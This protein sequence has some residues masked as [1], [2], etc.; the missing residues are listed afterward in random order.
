MNKSNKEL[1]DRLR[2]PVGVRED[3][4]EQLRKIAQALLHAAEQV[5][6]G[7]LR[8]DYGGLV[9]AAGPGGN[10][11]VSG[12]LKLVERKWDGKEWPNDGPQ[13]RCPP[14]LDMAELEARTASALAAGTKGVALPGAPCPSCGAKG[15]DQ[16]IL[17][18]DRC[19]FCDGTEG[20][21]PPRPAEDDPADGA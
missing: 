12:D 5:E 13:L 21:N 18:A 2:A 17:G 16:S 15:F 3:A 14:G 6:R 11:R 4:P 10:L 20:G 19:T 8:R 9:L 1:I 7:A